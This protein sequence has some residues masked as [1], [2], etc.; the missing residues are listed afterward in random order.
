MASGDQLVMSFYDFCYERMIVKI[1]VNKLENREN[2][3]RP[4]FGQKIG[5]SRAQI[6]KLGTTAE[7]MP[8]L[9]ILTCICGIFATV[10]VL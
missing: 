5:R 9:L 8:K 1:I 3:E 4:I 6:G 10:T 2:Q 7:A